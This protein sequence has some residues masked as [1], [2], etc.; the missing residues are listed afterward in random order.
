MIAAHLLEDRPIKSLRERILDGD[1]A[2]GPGTLVKLIRD[3]YRVPW[4]SVGVVDQDGARDNRARVLFE[5]D[6]SLWL[7]WSVLTE[8]A[9]LP[10]D[11]DALDFEVAWLDGLQTAIDEGGIR[12]QTSETPQAL[13]LLMGWR[14]ARADNLREL[15]FEIAPYYNAL[16]RI[17][18]AYQED[19][20]HAR[21]RTA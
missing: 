9:L 6:V 20:R 13:A 3:G 7:P 14:D 16:V 5:G 4:G 18:R 10:S 11:L 1:G 8:P 21:N 12:S 17:I 15:D 19:I 2:A